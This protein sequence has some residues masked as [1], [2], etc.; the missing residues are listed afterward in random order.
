MKIFI[1]CSSLSYGG[2]ERVAALLAN[3]FVQHSHITTVLTNLFE[4]QTYSLDPKVNLLNLVKSNNNKIWKWVSSFWLMR[5][6]LKLNRPDVVIGIMESYSFLS[7]VTSLGLNI[8]VV[9]T[10]HN[11][12]E[13]PP[14]APL[15]PMNRFSKFILN[16]I[17]KHITVLT[18]ADK[19]FIG[20]RLH[21][22]TVMPNPL[23]L[24][25]IDS[26]P[27]KSKTI[28]AVGRL[29]DWHCKGFDVLIHAWG[30]IAKNHPVW[31]L[32]IAGVGKE[33]YKKLLQKLAW[34]NNV[35]KQFELL[36]FHNNIE[37]LYRSS[38]IFVL[39]SRY[40]GFG[41]VLIEAMSQGCAC[42]ACDYNGRQRE[43]ITSEEEGVIC[44]PDNI[45]EL[46][47]SI[48]KL[49]TDETHLRK[50]QRGAIERSKF[51]SLE[52][53]IIRWEKYLETIISKK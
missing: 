29:N 35:S 51:Y 10:E 45:D 37:T 16:K 12:F 31:R 13:R 11:S 20:E 5:K 40:E 47:L 34:D 44:T 9:A 52:N 33:E 22:I 49:I 7:W 30:K 21:N 28:L 1:V 2:A 3:G 4:E 46:A 15:T 23:S 43:I 19:L 32:Q 48:E 39:S 8:P 14:Y 53:T 38:E 41:L 36:G 24:T 18:D 17:Y 6:Y 50:V 42:V 25:P 27:S 26:M